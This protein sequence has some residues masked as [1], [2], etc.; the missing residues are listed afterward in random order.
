MKIVYVMIKKVLL[1]GLIAFCTSAVCTA[2]SPSD[3]SNYDWEPLM[4]AVIK[5]ESNGNAKAK[6]GNQVGAMQIT[7][8]LVKE[9]N[10]ILQ[11]RGCSKRY[12]LTDRYSVE[13]S[14]EMFEIYQ[15]YHNPENDVEFAIRSWNGGPRFSKRATQRYYR[16]VMQHYKKTDA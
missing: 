10:Q 8:I 7:P 9:C 16:K 14:K 15:S 11:R 4:A 13:K 6:H 5:V 1:A 12:T 3:N 2:E